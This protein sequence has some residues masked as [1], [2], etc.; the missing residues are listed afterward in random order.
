MHAAC[1]PQSQIYDQF[2]EIVAAKV[3]ALKMGDGAAPDT[4]HGPLITPAG[5]DKARAQA[6][7]ASQRGRQQHAA[8]NAFTCCRLAVSGLC[9]RA[10]LGACV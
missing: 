2:A 8:L 4:T 3:A 10:G 7:A 6:T 5:V 9:T 1:R